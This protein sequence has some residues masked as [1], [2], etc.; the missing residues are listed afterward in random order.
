MSRGRMSARSGVSCAPL[1]L[2]LDE[3]VDGREVVKPAAVD[4]DL[5]AGVRVDK[6]D[7]RQTAIRGFL[8][9]DLALPPSQEI[10]GAAPSIIERYLG[11]FGEV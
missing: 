8:G 1:I 10:A 11:D 2:E 6:R 3:P 5:Q 7:M 4:G 9:G